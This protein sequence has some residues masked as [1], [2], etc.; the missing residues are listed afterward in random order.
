MKFLE[1]VGSG[2]ALVAAS[3][4]SAM[5][6]VPTEVTGALTDAQADGVKV[7]GAVL[8]VLIAIGAFKFIRRAL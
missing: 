1:K 3:V 6:E 8:V 7:A 2:F 4:G 5:A